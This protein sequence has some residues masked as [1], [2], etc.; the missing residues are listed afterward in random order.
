MIV[1]YASDEVEVLHEM[2]SVDSS[3]LKH[4]LFQ[5]LTLMPTVLIVLQIMMNLTLIL[6]DTIDEVFFYIRE[7]SSG[8]FMLKGVFGLSLVLLTSMLGYKLQQ[9]EA[10][11]SAAMSTNVDAFNDHGLDEDSEATNL[12]QTDLIQFKHI[13][14][15]VLSSIHALVMLLHGQSKLKDTELIY[16]RY[17]YDKYK[18]ELPK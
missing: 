4:N 10:E 1:Q 7:N 6:L 9:S 15:C 13:I 14:A 3:I 5:F 17:L 16:M 11:D 18:K 8:I 2:K 12:I